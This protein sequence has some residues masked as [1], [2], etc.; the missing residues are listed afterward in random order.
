MAK[1]NYLNNR[2]LLK[3]IH[4]SKVSYCYFVDQKYSDY[5]VIVANLNEVTSNLIKESLQTKADRLT[6]EK[7]L[8]LK[9]QGLKTAVEPVTVSELAVEDLVIRVMT[10][11]HIPINELY[12]L[13]MQEMPEGELPVK[14]RESDQYVKLNFPAFKH[15]ILDE[16][17]VNRLGNYKDMTFKEVGRSHWKNGLHNGEFCLFHG[18]MTNKLVM[19]LMKLVERYSYRSNWRGYTY[20]EEMKGQA[21]LQ[22]SQ[23]GLQF[24][25]ARGSN[26]FAYYTETMNNS[27][28][29]ILNMEKKH[30]NIRDDLL[31]AAGSAPSMTRQL[32]NEDDMRRDEHIDHATT[33]ESTT[34]S[35][36]KKRGRG[37]KKL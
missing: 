25:E 15:Y 7:K 28:T 13:K 26:P 31:I 19:M 35:T 10:Y 24:N 14:K 16:F 1:T 22:L 32:A 21:L 29:R 36:E 9:E 37:R 12:K 2:D 8:K 27:F 30:Q 3:E 18:K 33:G 11:E 17:S 5:D 6:K 20:V 23:I 34:P 4:K